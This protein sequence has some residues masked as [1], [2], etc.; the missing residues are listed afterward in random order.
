M[1]AG[2]HF[3]MLSALAYDYPVDRIIAGA[4][5]HQR[6]D[7]ASVLGELL[8]MY[9][10]SLGR[11]MSVE[12]PDVIVPVPLHRRRWAA[13]GF[14]QAAEIA[15]PVA[16]QLG[17][18]LRLDACHRI[19]HTLEQTSLTGSARRHNLVGA[20][21]APDDLTGL[22]LAIVDDVLTTGSTALAVAA[23]VKAAGARDIQIWTV[24]RTV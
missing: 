11:W 21:A 22:R 1:P 23:A 13:R 4:K 19:R 2:R 5:F 14:N 12:L 16:R 9:L 15:A 3:R 7:F 18:S 8:A 6:L 20:F 17:L 24:A 10:F